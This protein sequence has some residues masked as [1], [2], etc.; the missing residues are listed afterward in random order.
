MIDL[1]ESLPKK[2]ACAL[3]RCYQYTRFLRRPS[4]RFYP[5]CSEY[6]LRS[7]QRHGL[8]KG[9]IAGISRI[10]RCHPWNAGGVDEVPES[11]HFFHS[12]NYQ[13]TER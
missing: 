9:V 4:C 3:I 2:T 13:N 5:S 11:I 8:L 12:G 10:S 7:I 6:T 1:L